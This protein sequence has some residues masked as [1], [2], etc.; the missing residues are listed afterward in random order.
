MILVAFIIN[1]S[2][3]AF[4][5]KFS[6]LNHDYDFSSIEILFHC[7][8]Y[9]NNK[10]TGRLYQFKFYYF[11]SYL[12]LFLKNQLPLSAHTHTHTLL[13]VFRLCVIEQSQFAPIID[14]R[15]HNF[16]ICFCFKNDK[17]ESTAIANFI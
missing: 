12:K 17:Q 5:L 15:K 16:I 7:I 2:Q 11:I 9:M 14:L 3:S 1:A 10:K 4:Y 6:T 13:C 8:P